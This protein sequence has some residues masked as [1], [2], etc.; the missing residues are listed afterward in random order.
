MSTA[1]AALRAG[2]G[3]KTGTKTSSWQN[4]RGLVP[5]L[6]KYTGAIALGMLTLAVMGLIGN[7][8]PLTAGI[9]TDTLSGSARPFERA[10]HGANDV[11]VLNW[12]SKLIPYYEPHSRRT[13]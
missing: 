3:K 10:M 5:Y 12:L 11:T 4:L 9:I 2:V 6:G 8:V 1:A 7:L 13:L